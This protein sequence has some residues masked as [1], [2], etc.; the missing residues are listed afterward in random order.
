MPPLGTVCTGCKRA[1][2]D[3]KELS[4]HKKVGASGGLQG[5]LV[6]FSKKKI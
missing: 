2:W 6:E 4:W 3:K 5:H 1:V